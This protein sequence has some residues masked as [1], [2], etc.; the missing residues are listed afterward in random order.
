MTQPKH[1][2]FLSSTPLGNFDFDEEEPGAP[3]GENEQSSSSAEKTTTRIAEKSQTPIIDKFCTD[4]TSLAEQGALDPVVGRQTEMLRVMQILCRRKKNNPVLI[5]DPGV[6]KTAVVEGIAQLIATKNVPVPLENKRIVTLNMAT[7]VAGTQFRGQFEERVRKLM[8]EVKKHKEIIVFIDEIHTIIGAGS[9][10]G[11]LDAAN[12]LKPALARGEMQ[13]IGATSTAEY[14]KSI[15]K[16]AAL[17]RRFQKILLSPASQ[18]ETLAILKQLRSR[19]EQHHNTT[20]TDEALQA[21]VSLTA[22]YINGRVLPDKAIDAMDEAGAKARIRFREMP[23]EFTDIQNEISKLTEEKLQAAKSQDYERAAQLRDVIQ[24]RAAQLQEMRMQWEEQQKKSPVRVDENDVA[25]TVSMMSGVPVTKVR[26][27]DT[28]RL[29]NMGAVLRERIVGQDDAV[30]QV[31]RAL[32]RNRLGLSGGDRPIGTF[33]FVGPTGVG[34]T[35]LVKCLAEQLFGSKDALIRVDMSEYGEK[36]SVSRL[37]GAPP[38]YVGYEEGGQLTD[39]VRRKPYS[40]VL[41]DEIEKA[42]PDVFNTLLQVMDEGRLTDGNGVTADFRNTLVVMTSNSGTRQLREVGAGMGFDRNRDEIAPE[43]AR[44]V[45]MNALKKQFA[46]E[47]LNRLD[48]II[49]FNPL[50][51]ENA[52]Q[53]TDLELKELLD[54]VKKMGYALKITDNAKQFILSKGFDAQYGARSLKRAVRQY[55]EDPLCDFLLEGDTQNNDKL[56]LDLND[57]KMTVKAGA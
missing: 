30:E 4:L 29:K 37:V 43:K 36:F 19:Y 31:S 5:G 48:D 32:V 11:S 14:K 3:R 17:E 45:I 9:A 39:R 51:K 2:S 21:C 20:Y 26:E 40:V 8:E 12:M 54:R 42:H 22:R 23:S 50:N 35:Y 28:E 33:L 41:L 27:S 18:E 15:E 13:C 55:V 24:Q 25:E 52:S 57:E 7:L 10:P 1:H 47:F 46:P 53:I 6:G 56:V 49:V 38:G 34:K 44:S 16:D